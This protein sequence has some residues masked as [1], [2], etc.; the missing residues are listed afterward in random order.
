MKI[1]VCTTKTT[2]K[3]LATKK[4]VVLTGEECGHPGEPANGTLLSSEAMFYPGEQVSYT[5]NK[6]GE[7]QLSCQLSDFSS[8]RVFSCQ[9]QSRE[10]DERAAK[11]DAGLATSLSAVSD[12]NKSNHLNI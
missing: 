9:R 7:R 4:I 10:G 1:I 12:T 2:K 5:C 6:V 3:T 11:M 8:S